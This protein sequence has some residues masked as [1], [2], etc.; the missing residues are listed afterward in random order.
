[1]SIMSGEQQA[2]SPEPTGQ[3]E[4]RLQLARFGELMEELEGNGSAVDATGQDEEG[5]EALPEL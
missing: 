2:L 4:E 3:G 1:M 5:Y